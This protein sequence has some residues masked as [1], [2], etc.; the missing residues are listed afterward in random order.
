MMTTRTLGYV[1]PLLYT[2]KTRS[3]NGVGKWSW[4]MIYF[5][6]M[7]LLAWFFTGGSMAPS[8]ARWVG[9]GGLLAAAGIIP[10]VLSLFSVYEIGHL[11]HDTSARTTKQAPVFWLTPEEKAE[12]RAQL[13]ALTVLKLVVALGL[14]AFSVWLASGAGI[15]AAQGTAAWGIGGHPYY[16]FGLLAG[17]MAL[18]LAV[19]F[20]HY[21]LQGKASILTFGLLSMLK[22]AAPA[23][24]LLPLDL[25]SIPVLLMTVFLACSMPCLMEYAAHKGVAGI[26]GWASEIDVLRIRYYCVL[27]ALCGM[28]WAVGK[29]WSTVEPF[30]PKAGGLIPAS[31]PWGL[32]LHA[33]E[34]IGFVD[35]LLVYFLIYWGV[36][37]VYRSSQEWGRKLRGVLGKNM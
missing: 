15:Y 2:L 29:I 30:L 20:V 3:K 31:G 32:S 24:V 28:V 14:A 23:L 18:L 12:V 16:S 9:Q 13:W 5:V 8:T 35:A 33:V 4:V 36:L 19:L 34:Y 17:A 6:P 11:H 10:A 1:V 27:S 22:Y 21:R 37:L 7:L 25:R 26:R